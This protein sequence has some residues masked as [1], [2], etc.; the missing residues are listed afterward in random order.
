MNDAGGARAP[1]A[2][3]AYKRPQ[4]LRRTWESLRANHGAAASDLIVYCDGPK[5]PA[6]TAEVAAAIAEIRRL[7]AE[8]GFRSVE[9]VERPANLGLARSIITGVGQAVERWDRVIVIE[10]DLIT[11]PHFLDFMNDGLDLYAA[12]ELVA[13]LHGFMYP[14]AVPARD[15]LF[16]RGADCWGWATWRRAWRHFRGDGAA[17]LADLRAAGLE[18]RFDHG[19]SRALMRMLSDQVAGRNDSWAIRWHAS[20]FLAGMCTLYPARSLVHNIGT[21]ASGTHCGVDDRYHVAVCQE[22]IPV[23]RI[24]VAE[25]EATWEVLARFHRS[26]RRPLRALGRLLSRVAGRFFR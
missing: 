25:D 10:D 14:V 18:W 8:G 5:R 20:A 3:F 13:S 26:G 6:D 2:L 19:G 4:H 21:D 22:R 15:T 11:S 16:L 9:V 17:L 7:A 1:I 23:E 24:P 12:D